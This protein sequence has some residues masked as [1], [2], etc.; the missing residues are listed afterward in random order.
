[1]SDI[2]LKYIVTHPG[3][4]HR[5][6][7]IAIGLLLYKLGPVDVH[8]RNPGHAE[9]ADPQV[10]VVDVGGL[11][12][13]T[14]LNFDHH[15]FPRPTSPQAANCA[16]SL[17]AD[18]FAI[19]SLCRRHLHWWQ[20]METMDAMGPQ[21]A[22]ALVKT[23]PPD[24]RP[25]ISPVETTVLREFEKHTLVP[26]DH[27]TLKMAMAVWESYWP[28]LD[29]LEAELSAMEACTQQCVVDGLSVIRVSRLPN[30]KPV[31]PDLTE[32]YLAQAGLDPAIV[33]S[34]D[35]RGPGWALF[36]RVGHE[37][38]VDLSVV[39]GTP[40]VVFAHNNGFIAKTA[41]DQDPI[42]VL[43]KAVQMTRLKQW[44]ADHAVARV[45]EV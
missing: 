19:Q 21:T 38:K 32:R 41:V 7:F 22:A 36:R 11:W 37:A 44:E 9:L 40:G 39:D 18:H 13:P 5:D 2:K 34:L 25:T 35:D 16:A 6:E 30:G 15:Q 29:Q 31:T 3:Q 27:W 1:M 43:K 23:T 8:R 45:G 10:A 26:A 33:I 42:L 14:Q 4:A 17:V 28:Y 24:L 20:F 12:T